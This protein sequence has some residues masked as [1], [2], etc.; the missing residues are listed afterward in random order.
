MAALQAIQVYDGGCVRRDSF[1]VLEDWWSPHAVT[2]AAPRFSDTYAYL[3]GE[4]DER[5]E[6][7]ALQSYVDSVEK[8][9]ARGLVTADAVLPLEPVN[10]PEWWPNDCGNPVS[11]L[12]VARS[13]HADLEEAAQRESHL[14]RLCADQHQV[15]LKSKRRIEVLQGYEHERRAAAARLQSMLGKRPHQSTLPPT[16][17]QPQSPALM[18]ATPLQV[19]GAPPRKRGRPPLRQQLPALTSHALEQQQQQQQLGDPSGERASHCVADSPVTFNYI[20]DGS[21]DLDADASFFHFFASHLEQVRCQT[22]KQ[23]DAQHVYAAPFVYGPYVAAASSSS[24]TGATDTPQSE[25]QQLVCVVPRFLAFFVQQFPQHRT[26]PS[27]KYETCFKRLFANTPNYRRIFTNSEAIPDVVPVALSS[28]VI[29]YEIEWQVWKTFMHSSRRCADFVANLDLH[30]ATLPPMTLRHFRN[31]FNCPGGRYDTQLPS[32]VWHTGEPVG[33]LDNRSNPDYHFKH[34]S[35]VADDGKA[36]YDTGLLCIELSSEFLLH[37][38]CVKLNLRTCTLQTLRKLF[39]TVPN[40][41][42]LPATEEGLKSLVLVE[43]STGKPIRYPT[44]RY[45]ERFG[46]T[47][48]SLKHGGVI[49]SVLSQPAKC[50]PHTVK[51]VKLV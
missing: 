21:K 37:P 10:L 4:E 42:P 13:L 39:A 12:E 19:G 22:Q 33:Y 43:A 23:R 31:A 14:K 36:E 24:E 3:G 38:A 11:P 50:K 49:R 6:Y 44:L 7:E 9:L 8:R 18:D 16:P 32:M 27:A 26:W 1:G 30:P 35:C 5:L 47:L 48:H 40:S 51:E 15:L 34:F 17:P 20:G 25:Q 2:S 46:Y 28:G 45:F 29:C 41:P